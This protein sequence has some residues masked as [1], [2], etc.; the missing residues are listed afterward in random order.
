MENFRMGKFST[1]HHYVTALLKLL[2]GG[3][4]ESHGSRGRDMC[5][6]PL[7]YEAG[8]LASGPRHSVC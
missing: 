1:S 5:Q 4:E 8:V 3:S 6:K 7:V 2:L